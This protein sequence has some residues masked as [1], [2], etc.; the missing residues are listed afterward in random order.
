MTNDTH[1]PLVTLTTL[2]ETFSYVKYA[3]P[4][5][6]CIQ[7]SSIRLRYLSKWPGEPRTRARS[8]TKIS[9]HEN[10]TVHTNIK[11]V[12][13]VTKCNQDKLSRL[14]SLF[15]PTDAQL[16]IPKMFKFTLTL[17]LKV[18]LHIYM[19]YI[20]WPTKRS[21]TQSYSVQCTIHTPN[22]VSPINYVI[23]H[24]DFTLFSKSIILT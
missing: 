12:S 15:H 23:T 18:F 11:V 8:L 20:T 1:Q 24:S 2:F 22:R 21:L 10:S 13:W 9:Q 19:W 3:L 6:W 16:N 4:P 5:S 7:L 17:T 14:K